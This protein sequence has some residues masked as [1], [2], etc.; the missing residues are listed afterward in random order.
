[1]FPDFTIPA[2]MSGVTFHAMGTSIWLL[3]PNSRAR[4]AIDAVRGLFEEWEQ[5]L[6]RFL[7]E[8][9]L[10]RL[11]R[12]AGEPVQV[13]AL[14]Y[15]VLHSAL[16]AAQATHGLYDPTLQK[17]IVALGY[18]RSFELLANAPTP[19]REASWAPAP[20]GGWRR[21]RV[22]RSDRRVTLPPGVGLDFGGIAK[23]MAVDASIARLHELGVESA[24]VSAGGD[25]AV[26]GHLAG[27]DAWP[28]AVSGRDIGWELPLRSG[29]L[30][31]SGIARRRWLRDGRERHHLLDPRTGDS[32]AS[33]LW[34]VSVVADR[35]EQ[36]EVAA[37]V[38]FVLGMESGAAF[39][40]SHRLAGLLV[41]ADGSWQAVE[42][43]P[44]DLAQL[45][46][47]AVTR[48][49]SV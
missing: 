10:S 26:L 22:D 9:E 14:L 6:S 13:S 34:S 35:C 7:P 46:D 5:R 27:A 4:V 48:E 33:E 37:K 11:N 39:L 30:A 32:A 25:L 24:L 12:S 20:G 36:A 16:A 19:R 44:G 1:V 28:I 43:W 18:D 38:A 3:L 2:G 47:P 40:R 31:T 42:P 8:S 23:G 29:A 45:S 17:Q 49:L 21:I 41:G 15:T